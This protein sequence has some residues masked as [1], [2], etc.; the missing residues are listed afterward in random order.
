M[1]THTQIPIIDPHIHLWDPKNTPKLVSPLVKKFGWSN[2]V[3]HK[4]GKMLLPKTLVEFVGK[5]DYVLAPHLPEIFHRDTGKYKVDGYVHI[6]A[7]WEGDEI[8]TPVGETRWLETLEDKPMAIVGEAHLSRIDILDEVLD[9]HAAAS[10]RFAGVRDM[11]AAHPDTERIFSWA[12]HM[13][14]MK[15]EDFKKGYRR[16]AERGLT[17][18]AYVYAGQL[19]EL[20]DFIKESPDTSVVLNHVGT[21]V[22]VGGPYAGYGSTAAERKDIQTKWYA[23]LARVAENKHV[24]IKLSGLFMPIVGYDYHKRS[25]P[26]TADQVAKDIGSHIKYAIDTFGA[27]RCMFASNFPMDKALLSYEMLYDAYFEIVKDFSR[28]DQRKLFY[29]NAKRFY[30]I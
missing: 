27:D 24:Y 8:T 19:E 30:G 15:S 17:Y 2:W 5:T 28:E 1:S 7:G 9:A 22:G 20:A 23:G 6:Q 10:K 25:T 4:M 16:L 13:D 18:D 12:E 3:L 29:D 11:L 14:V 26:V 21:P